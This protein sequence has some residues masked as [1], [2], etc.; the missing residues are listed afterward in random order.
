[1]A[2]V[3]LRT[4]LTKSTVARIA[5]NIA[6]GLVRSDF[7]RNASESDAESYVARRSV[8]LAR[9]ICVQ[10]EA[11]EPRE[12]ADYTPKDDAVTCSLCRESR[13]LVTRIG[14]WYFCAPCAPVASDYF[15][16]AVE[17]M[18]ERLHQIKVAYPQEESLPILLRLVGRKPSAET[19]GGYKS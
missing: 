8:S 5:G 19:Y 17:T 10:V 4:E 12:F 15:A 1:M 18:R 6:S 9:Q 11:T 14:G 7:A 16:W 2:N 3:S 13:N